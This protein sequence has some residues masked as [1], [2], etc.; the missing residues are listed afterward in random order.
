MTAKQNNWEECLPCYE[1]AYNNSVNLSTGETPFFLNHGRHARIPTMLVHNSNSPAAEDF[2]LHLTN[3]IAAARDHILQNQ[4]QAADQRN[5]QFR[6]ATFKVGDL[7]LLS[8]EHYNLQLPSEKLSPLR[9]GPLKVL[10]ILGPNTVK[11]EVPPRLRQITPI[12]NV[13]YLTPYISRKPEI[14][15]L[16]QH[17]PPN[18]VDNEE[19]FEVED[20]IAHRGQ[21]NR[22]QYLVRF[23][24]YGPEDDLWLPAKNLAHAP[25]ILQDYLDRQQNNPPLPRSNRNAR[26]P[27]HLHRLGHLWFSS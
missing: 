4:G 7:V 1:F 24:S 10:Q 25:D 18:L 2:V 6:P 11:V 19:E 22:T 8:T 27:R 9:I 3:G 21:G 12:Q 13:E 20:I 23:K 5:R 16:V 14:G 17:D 26:A 15:P